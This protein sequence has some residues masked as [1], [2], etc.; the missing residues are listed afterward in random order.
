MVIPKETSNLHEYK[1]KVRKIRRSGLLGK[2]VTRYVWAT[3]FRKAD[4]KFKK[5]HP[6]YFVEEIT[7]EDTT[8]IRR[9]LHEDQGNV[10]SSL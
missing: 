6:D 5:A 4:M 10:Q 2:L 8:R 9:H 3:T 7:P 1:L